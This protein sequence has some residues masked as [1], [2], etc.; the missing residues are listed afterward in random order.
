MLN[1]HQIIESSFGCEPDTI[2]IG[3][4]ARQ[5]ESSSAPASALVIHES[6]PDTLFKWR[7]VVEN[8]SDQAFIVKTTRICV[9]ID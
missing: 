4:G 3:G 6:G 9:P 5:D 2:V 1:P 8:T 7:F